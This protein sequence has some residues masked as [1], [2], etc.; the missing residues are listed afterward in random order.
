MTHGNKFEAWLGGKMN[1][2]SVG[3]STM[4]Q[5]Q[6]YTIQSVVRSSLWFCMYVHTSYQ[7]EWLKSHCPPRTPLCTLRSADAT[8]GKSPCR[9]VS[10]LDAGVHTCH[11]SPVFGLYNLKSRN[12]H[13]HP[14]S[15][16]TDGLPR[17]FKLV[18]GPIN[19]STYCFTLEPTQ[20]WP[21]TWIYLPIFL[22]S[23]RFIE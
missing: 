3:E 17:F 10:T 12:L 8:G 16:V 11:G 23:S 1:R 7:I 2:G 21:V 15:K 4:Q 18:Y 5:Q 9:A 6:Q 19:H 14:F 13:S 22:L 20:N